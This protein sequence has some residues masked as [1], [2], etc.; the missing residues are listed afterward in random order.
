MSLIFLVIFLAGC[1]N[2]PLPE[3]SGEISHMSDQL[4]EIYT[5][6]ISEDTPYY[7]DGPQ[8]A[9]SRDGFLRK[10]TQIIILQNRGSYSLVLTSEG[11][12]AYIANT[13]FE[14]IKN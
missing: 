3:N 9:R 11:I 14:R 5:H 4:P 7:I 13:S 8:Q 2:L 12:K 6:S 10:N 1:Q